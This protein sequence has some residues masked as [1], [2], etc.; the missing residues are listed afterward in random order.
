MKAASI[1]F[2]FAL[3]Y[4]YSTLQ[5]PHCFLIVII[6]NCS[7]NTGRE[8]LVDV[9]FTDTTISKKI[10]LILSLSSLI[11]SH[12]S[13]LFSIRTY[14]SL[15]YSLAQHLCLFIPTRQTQIEVQ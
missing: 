8:S 6:F 12:P 13:V 5:T 1:C 10:N 4:D 2:C 7:M 14:L 3:K 15:P 9:L 11:L